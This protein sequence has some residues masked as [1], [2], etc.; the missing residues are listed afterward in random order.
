MRSHIKTRL[1]WSYLL[2]IILTVLLFQLIILS[3][4][5]FYYIES[6]EDHLFNEGMMFNSFYEQELLEETITDNAPLLLQRYTFSVD[7]QVQVLDTDGDVLADTHKSTQKNMLAFSDVSAALNGNQEVHKWNLNG[8]S[9]LSVSQPITPGDQVLGIIRL[10]TSLEQ[11]NS[12]YQKNVFV[13][14]LIGLFV[15]FAAFLVSYF[16]AGTITKPVSSITSA[17]EQMASGKFSTRIPKQKNDELGQLADTLNFMAEEVERHERLKNEFI[18]SVSHELRTPLTSVKGWAIT[19]HSMSEDKFFQEGLEI[20]SSESDRLSGLLGDLLDLSSFSAGKAAYKFEEIALKNLLQQVVH[21]LKPRAERQGIYLKEAYT[22]EPVVSG[23][24]NRLK[25]VLIN[26]FDNA[27]KFTSTNGEI[28]AA[29]FLNSGAAQ[30][31]IT[32]TGKG[33][34][35][36]E[37]QFVTEKFHKGAS[38]GAGTGLGLAIC[39]EIIQAHGGTFKLKSAVTKGTTV[40]IR[41]PL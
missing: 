19:L 27:L 35:A 2:L 36:E 7:A 12:I 32:D 1:I 9:V 18:A 40:E 41:L 22:S 39:Q 30:I 31:S 24:P 6:I 3:A 17:A 14:M 11:V 16:L 21:Q 25:Q 8:E 4:L 38:K 34:P 33:I 10:T 26:V 37:L 29:L 23:D 13:L 15:V 5:R 28:T 20:I